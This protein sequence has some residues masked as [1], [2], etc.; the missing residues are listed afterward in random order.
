VANKTRLRIG[1]VGS[2]R[3]NSPKDKALIKAVLERFISKYP[4]VSVVLVS[5]GCPK[6]ADHFAEELAI[7]M[8]LEIIIHYPDKSKLPPS[9]TKWDY[10][11]ICYERNTLIANDSELLIA[12]VAS[13]RKGGTEDTIRKIGEKP[14]I[15]L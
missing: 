7:E 15:L 8:G 9:N 1:V 10:A 6:G 5:G 3:R 14:C 4:D 2:R 12:V 11:K 13:D